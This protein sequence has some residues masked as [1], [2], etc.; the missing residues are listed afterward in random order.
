MALGLAHVG[1]FSYPVHN[2]I[3]HIC[4]CVA[5]RYLTLLRK[6]AQHWKLEKQY[7]NWLEQ[8]PEIAESSDRGVEYYTSPTGGNLPAWPK[9]RIGGSQPTGRGGGRGGGRGRGK[10]RGRGRQAGRGGGEQISS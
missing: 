9:I 3:R 7:T 5:R 8:H 10:G 6:G 1:C 4:C 2:I